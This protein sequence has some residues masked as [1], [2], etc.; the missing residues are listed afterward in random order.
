MT[1]WTHHGGQLAKARTTFGDGDA[2]WIDL[3]TGINPRQWPGV[4]RLAIDWS[5]LPDASAL[6]G[7]ETTAARYFGADPACV[8]AVPGTEIGLRLLGGHLPRPVRYGW[9]SYGTHAEIAP[10]G[11]AVDGPDPGAGTLILANP[12]NP[13]G[14]IT[15][16]AALRAQLAAGWLVLDEAFADTDPRHSL[17]G[18]VREA[19]P[20]IVLRSFGKFFGLAGVRLG[21]VIAPPE[22]IATLRRHLGSWPVSAAAI[23]IGTAAYADSGWIEAERIRLA[24]DAAALDQLLRAHGHI[25]I[26]AC[27]LFRLI[28]TADAQ[29]LFERLARRSILTRPFDYDPRWLRIG[30]PADAEALDRL[31]SALAN[32]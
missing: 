21:F 16:A 29:A 19:T 6:T 23:A 8:L 27:P 24:A 11:V 1:P 32:G 12:N 15:P 10:D 9:P 5:R 28:E 13:D 22:L 31:D 4:A 3:S 2:P 17:A 20:L 7:L 18:A 25:P 26:G 14:R 30:L